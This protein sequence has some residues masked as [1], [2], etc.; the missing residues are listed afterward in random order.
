[1]WKKLKEIVKIVMEYIMTYL[2]HTYV[3]RNEKKNKTRKINVFQKTKKTRGHTHY[4]DF[5]Q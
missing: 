4:N 5:T 1:M 3:Y 2:Y